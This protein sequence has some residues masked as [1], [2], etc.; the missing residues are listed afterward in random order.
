MSKAFESA[1]DF[2]YL[3]Y[4]WVEELGPDSYDINKVNR[5]KEDI[6]RDGSQILETVV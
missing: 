3:C 6:G 2:D 4:A 5:I 1:T